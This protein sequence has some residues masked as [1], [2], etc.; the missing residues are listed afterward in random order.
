M[1]R[2]ELRGLRL[3]AGGRVLLDGVALDAAGG[4]AVAVVG[5]SG[6]GKT[7]LLGVLAG[8]AAPEGGQV[9][10]DGQPL[11]PGDREHVARTGR[12][13]Q[14][15]ALLPVLTAAENVE[16]A[17]RA[18]GTGG[19]AA[20][21][22]A[23]SAL[24]RVGLGEVADRPA[25]RLSGG[26]R[27]RVGVARALVHAPGLLL[28]DEPTSELDEATRDAVV[29][30]LRDEVDRGTLLVVATHDAAVAGQCEQQLQLRPV[31]ADGARGVSR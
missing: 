18:R 15:H 31:G 1:T 26:Q 2:L 21:S 6:S 17:L 20:R 13:L 12:V 23:L 25:G 19:P 14:L 3:A 27:Q 30:V 10:V 29:A 5:P 22:L 9:L 28:L 24:E 16:V 8:D 11:R 4:S 7:S